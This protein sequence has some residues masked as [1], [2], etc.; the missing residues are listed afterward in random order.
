MA[1]EANVIDYGTIAAYG[2]GRI[3]EEIRVAMDSVEGDSVVLL[4]TNPVNYQRVVLE[5]MSYTTKKA[6]Y[7]IYVAINKPF[8]AM[9][10]I[11]EKE[12]DLSR[13]IFVDAITQ[14]L[15]GNG[16][17]GSIY[18]AVKQGLK[19]VEGAH[20]KKLNGCYYVASPE[21]LTDLCEAITNSVHAVPNESKFIFFD[22]FSTLLLYNDVNTVARF[23]HFL[24]GKIRT[25]GAKGVLLSLENSSDALTAQLSQFCDAVIKIG[26][27]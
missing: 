6:S 9:K 26:V 25:W 5:L 27:D 2:A 1:K 21:N 7:G 15:N 20:I 17:D 11:L 4:L 24:T 3:R 18:V 19:K 10:N 13:V 8:V 12:V 14:T 23:A 16:N 22:S